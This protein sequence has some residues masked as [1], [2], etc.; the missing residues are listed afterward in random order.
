[1][2]APAPSVSPELKVL[3][4]RLRLG[5]LLDTL[6]ERLALARSH[7]LSH[8][9]FL[10]QLFSDEVQRRDADSAGLRARAAHL[11][12]HMYL[13]AW[14]ETAAVSYDR[15]VLSELVS[16]R[17]VDQ[18][19]NALILGPVGV[20]K[21]FLATAL[22]HI[23]C[24]R[25]V[26]VHFERADRLHKRL[27]AARLDASYEVEMRKL[28]G[29]EL[30]ILDDFALQALDATET[31]DLYELVVERHHSA[32]T[33]LTSNR[34]PV[35]AHR[36]RRTCARQHLKLTCSG[37]LVRQT[38]V[39]D[40]ICKV[41]NETFGFHAEGLAGDFGIERYHKVDDSRGAQQLWRHA[42]RVENVA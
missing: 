35:K 22:G 39:V 33:V 26:S 20:G 14:D 28:I 41:V 9:E 17:F 13:E 2:T 21:T 8:V 18:G 7:E 12:P 3:M 42:G 36:F 4:R 37:D 16:L 29:V 30:L 32:A 24:R 23:A 31:A 1:M 19:R 40:V 27:R 10:E 25:R 15:A 6:P 34:D 11:D 38:S 5:R